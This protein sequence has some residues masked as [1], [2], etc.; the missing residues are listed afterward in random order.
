MY[1]VYAIE[2]WYVLIKA[3][4][5]HWKHLMAALAHKYSNTKWS[6]FIYFD[7]YSSLPW[8]SLSLS[9]PHSHFF[10][11]LLTTPPFFNLCSSLLQI[12]MQT[13]KMA[14]TV[15]R[16]AAATFIAHF[17]LISRFPL[18]FSWNNN[19]RSCVARQREFIFRHYLY[20]PSH[21]PV[22][23]TFLS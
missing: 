15:T 18:L 1:R 3:T 14:V 4:K 19:N 12:E 7:R 13:Q 6:F 21:F 2:W 23:R 11:T 5:F 22:C 8:L 20:S 9:E 10:L 16:A 17:N